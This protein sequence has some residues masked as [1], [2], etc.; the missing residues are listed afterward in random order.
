MVEYKIRSYNQPYGCFYRPIE[1]A[2]YIGIRD[3]ILDDNELISY[4]TDIITHEFIHYILYRDFGIVVSKLFDW[5]GNHFRTDMRTHVKYLNR[6]NIKYPNR[7]QVLHTNQTFSS[8]LDYYSISLENI[9]FAND[10]CNTRNKN[11]R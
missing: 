6:H 4:T 8:F 7:K 3:N 11:N 1:D 5:I 2:I 9:R 10:I